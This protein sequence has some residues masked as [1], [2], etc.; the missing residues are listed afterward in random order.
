MY[1]KYD[2]FEILGA[3]AHDWVGKPASGIFTRNDVGQTANVGGLVESHLYK[4]LAGRDGRFWRRGI[5]IR[6]NGRFARTNGLP[7]ISNIGSRQFHIRV[8][9]NYVA[10]AHNFLRRT[11]QGAAY[12]SMASILYKTTYDDTY[13][14]EGMTDLGFAGLA[15]YGGVKGIT[16][17]M[18]YIG[19]KQY[20][21]HIHAWWNNETIDDAE[22]STRTSEAIESGGD[23]IAKTIL[24]I[25]D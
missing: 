12:I 19:A 22:A 5:S 11:G 18:T 16:A 15:T 20:G 7:S 21:A 8:P 4:S 10:G 14:Y 1:L 23:K 6:S 25:V 3:M 13:R 17:N 2:V 9:S 24:D